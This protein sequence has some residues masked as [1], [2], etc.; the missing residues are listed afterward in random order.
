MNPLNQG[1]QLVS[2]NQPTQL[3]IWLPGSTN[4]VTW[5]AQFDALCLGYD[6]TSY[7]NGTFPYPSPADPNYQPWRR[8]DGLL[9]HTLMTFVDPLIAHLIASASSAHIAWMKL[10]QQ[11]ANKIQTR[12]YSFHDSL[13]RL[14]KGTKSIA[15]YLNK[16]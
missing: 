7:I 14:M 13:S 16:I 12:I 11:Y 5:K 15:Q 9:H 10:A 8:Q 3:P 1:S 2:I 6:Q 4:Y